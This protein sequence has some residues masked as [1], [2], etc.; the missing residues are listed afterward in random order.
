MPAHML[1]D[2]LGSRAVYFIHYSEKE[3]EENRT[4]CVLTQ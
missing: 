4:N 2:P 3:Y 1:N